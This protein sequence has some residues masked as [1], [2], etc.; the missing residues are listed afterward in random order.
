M[1]EKSETPKF[2]V[3]EDQLSLRLCNKI[4]VDISNA[5]WRGAAFMSLKDDQAFFNFDPA[6]Y[7]QSPNRDVFSMYMHQGMLGYAWLFLKEVS[8]IVMVFRCSILDF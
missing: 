8:Y 4:I 3:A 1:K 5:L 7:D 6:Y 2:P